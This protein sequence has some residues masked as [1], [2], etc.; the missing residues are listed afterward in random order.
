MPSGCSTRSATA[1][2]SFAGQLLDQA[3]L[4][5]DRDARLARGSSGLDQHVHGI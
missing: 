3:A 2:E 5:V 1:S 4:H